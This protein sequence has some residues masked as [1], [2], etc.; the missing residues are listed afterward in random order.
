M[1]YAGVCQDCG[2]RI[3][4]CRCEKGVRDRKMIDMEADNAA[5]RARVAELEKNAK[6]AWE[7]CHAMSSELSKANQDRDRWRECA[8]HLDYRGADYCVAIHKELDGLQAD[9]AEHREQMSKLLKTWKSRATCAE[10]EAE[11]YREALIQIDKHWRIVGGALSEHSV[12]CTIARK[13]L[14]GGE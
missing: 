2:Q 9:N 3:T 10:A 6:K 13:A 14:E 7:E 1:D 8:V 11:R 12:I 5:L 4:F